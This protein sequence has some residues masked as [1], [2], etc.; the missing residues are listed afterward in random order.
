M[1]SPMAAPRIFFEA[2]GPQTLAW[3]DADNQRHQLSSCRP[4]CAPASI[5][6]R[7][8]LSRFDLDMV[9]AGGKD[10]DGAAFTVGRAS[11]IMRRDPK[12]D[13]LDLMHERGG[14]ERRPPPRSAITF[15]LWKS[16]ARSPRVR[17]L[18]GLL[19][20][21][22]A[23]WMRSWRGVIKRRQIVNGPVRYRNPAMCLRGQNGCKPR[24]HSGIALRALLFPLY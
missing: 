6:D 4:P 23:G 22:P 15:E 16:I 3:T 9:G 24:L 18:P 17:P 13:A 5:A 10:S 12:S 20:G 7:K 2:A 8:G 1:L 11:F 21:R 19:A 14:G